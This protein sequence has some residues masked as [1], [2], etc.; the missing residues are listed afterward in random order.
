MNGAPSTSARFS[1]AD[2]SASSDPSLSFMA[3][4]NRIFGI[5]QYGSTTLANTLWTKP[6]RLSADAVANLYTRPSVN[7]EGLS[8]PWGLKN[9]PIIDDNEI[10]SS[11][12]AVQENSQVE[13]IPEIAGEV[14]AV[15]GAAEVA[16]SGTPWTLAAI[17]NQQLGE[18]TSRAISTGMQNMSSQNFNSNIQSHGLNVGLNAQLI[19]S[20][21]EQ[22][23]RNQELGGTIG[24][25]FGPIGALI[26]HAVAGTV[27]AN[28]GLLN[29]AGSFQ[30]WIN[31]QQTG[32][33][34]SATTSG[35]QGVSE[36]TD[37]V[38]G[39]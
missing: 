39:Q 35:D 27:Q 8:D 13:E 9:S 7:F 32:I 25:F 11:E 14:E 18:V 34:A 29:T 28:P 17:V 37:T 1:V 23:I 3:G 33:V 15:E 10:K 30:G 19:Q 24:S 2:A 22:T 5:G 6:D 36:M 31:P 4:S 12:S 16:A 21:Q 26:G 38:N 20:Q